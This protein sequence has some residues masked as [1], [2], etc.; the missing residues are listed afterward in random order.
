MALSEPIVRAA[1]SAIVSKNAEDTQKILEEMICGG[2]GV[3]FIIT[4]IAW[5]K[6][7]AS[8]AEIALGKPDYL[9]EVGLRLCE[10]MS[11]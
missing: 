8:D 11:A 3:E 1:F 7:F 5:A 6:T 2:H 10:A 4:L 9:P